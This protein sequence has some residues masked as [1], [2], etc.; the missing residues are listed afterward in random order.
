MEKNDKQLFRGFKYIDMHK[1]ITWEVVAKEIKASLGARCTKE[2]AM[3]EHL[4]RL[5][6][7]DSICDVVSY[8]TEDKMCL[9]LNE[10]A[11][12]RVSVYCTNPS[13]YTL[14]LRI[15]YIKN[16]RDTIVGALVDVIYNI[17]YAMLERNIPVDSSKIA[18]VDTIELTL[19]DFMP[20]A[21]YN[22]ICLNVEAC[23]F[24]VLLSL[25]QEWA[26]KQ[27][28]DIMPFFLLGLI[29]RMTE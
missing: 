29:Y 8:Y 20:T 28:I 22:L 23:D 18:A 24:N 7:I 26:N 2:P 13:S 11:A 1:P 27:D 3:P 21:A 16:V 19:P 4:F 25:M 10:Y 6:I 14:S 5:S 17:L 15:G 9:I 12:E